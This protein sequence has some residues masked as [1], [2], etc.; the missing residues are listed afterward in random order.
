MLLVYD[1]VRGLGADT[2]TATGIAT[3]SRR[4][5]SVL[6]PD[7]RNEAPV[8]ES[9]FEGG[10]FYVNTAIGSHRTDRGI[11]CQCVLSNAS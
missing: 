9:R 4:S 5:R 6:L 7:P 2:A 11:P 1:S 10:D 3:R 8:F